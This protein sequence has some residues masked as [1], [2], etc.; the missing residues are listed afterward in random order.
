M[1]NLFSI[2]VLLDSDAA[3]QHHLR[4]REVQMTKTVLLV[5]VSYVA[6][7]LPSV[8][9]MV[10]DPMPPCRG[11]PG[12]CCSQNELQNMLHMFNFKGMS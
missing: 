4:H 12:K 1:I 9:L 10:V 7:F 5:C 11:Y 2:I 3:L 6:C 8:V